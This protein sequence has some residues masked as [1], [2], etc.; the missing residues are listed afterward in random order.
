MNTYEVR[1][2]F[3]VT[4]LVTADDSSEAIAEAYDLDYTVTT[5]FKNSAGGPEIYRAEIDDEV[6]FIEGENDEM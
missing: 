1:Q 3:V 5:Q 6:I 2:Y 4:L